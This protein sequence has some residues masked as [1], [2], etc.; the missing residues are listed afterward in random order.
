MRETGSRV[1]NIISIGAGGEDD[2]YLTF[3]FS[4]VFPDLEEGTPAAETRKKEMTTMASKVVPGTI[5][6]IREMVKK[7]EL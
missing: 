7:G 3:G 2:M 4:F 5:A 1:Q 6:T